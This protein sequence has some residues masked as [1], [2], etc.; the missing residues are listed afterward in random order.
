MSTKK[1]K[2]DPNYEAKKELT[3]FAAELDAAPHIT[4]KNKKKATRKQEKSKQSR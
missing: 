4:K 3:E 2:T 1:R